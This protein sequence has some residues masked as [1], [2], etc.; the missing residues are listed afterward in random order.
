M[1]NIKMQIRKT[2]SGWEGMLREWRGRVGGRMGVAIIE[3]HGIYEIWR[4]KIYLK[5]KHT[6]IHTKKKKS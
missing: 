4:I 2:K 3:I 1:T 6:H 5:L